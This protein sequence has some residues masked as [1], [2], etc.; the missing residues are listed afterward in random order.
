MTRG[1]PART[2]AVAVSA[3]AMLLGVPAMARAA[4][5]TCVTAP[6]DRFG[7]AGP[8]VQDVTTFANPVAPTQ[9]VTVHSPRSS[10]GPWPVLFLSHAFAAGDPELYYGA[11]IERLVSHGAIVV[12][13]SYGTPAAIISAP[14]AYDELWAGFEEAVRRHRESLGMDL[15]RVGFLGHSYGGGATP[16]MFRRGVSERGWGANGRFMQIFAPYEVFDIDAEQMAAFPPDTK[17]LL[18]V[19]DDDTTND[20]RFAIEHIWNRLTSIPAANRDYVLVHSAA[21][22]GC[23]LPADHGVPM[24]GGGRY[25][26]LD[27]YDPHAVWRHSVGLMACAFDDDAAG[28]DVALGHGSQQQTDM[29]AWLSDGT[30]VPRLVS[31]G[32][33]VPANCEAGERCAARFGSV[34][35]GNVLP[36]LLSGLRR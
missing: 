3:A 17:V 4:V 29:G 33:P 5:D 13:S 34:L 19:Y 15:S 26:K 21:N 28:C 1:T 25:G 24:S 16:E 18:Q 11:L 23:S 14:V 9:T 6:G 31:M 30:P 32:D 10:G 8:H 12:H 20:H 36:A 27:A 2:L 22:G 7:I 35:V